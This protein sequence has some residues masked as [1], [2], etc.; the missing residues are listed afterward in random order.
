MKLSDIINK[1]AQVPIAET[2]SAGGVAGVAQPVG[3]VISRKPRKNKRKKAQES[4][5][6]S[7]AGGPACWKGKKIHPTK[8]TK[9]K[10]GKRVN[11]CIDA[12]TNEEVE[13]DEGSR[14]WVLGALAA[15][16]MIGSIAGL[17]YTAK[18]ALQNDQQLQTLISYYEDAKEA[19]DR[20]AMKQLEKRIANQKARIVGGHGPV[21]G[22]DGKPIVPKRDR[23]TDARRSSIE[24][25]LHGNE[26]FEKYGWI[27]WPNQITEAEYQGRDVDLNKP[28]RSTNGPKKF[29]VYVNSGKKTK[30]GKIKVKKVNFGDPDMEIKRDDPEARKSFRARH[31]CDQKK[32][33]TTAGYWSCKKW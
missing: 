4:N 8:P 2:T 18:Q 6:K 3:N 22:A 29:H 30:D 11:N 28:V 31:K 7:P 23:T 19:G 10:G 24:E 27:E 21:M 12:G 5:K 16:G 15:M 25:T 1:D 32:D 26:F 33:K 13:L 14:E 17:D 20:N 9:I